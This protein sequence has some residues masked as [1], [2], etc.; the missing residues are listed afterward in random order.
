MELSLFLAKLFGIYF[1]IVGALWLFRKDMYTE[2]VYELFSSKA[3]LA[4]T[5]FISLVMGLAIAIGHPIFTFD[6]RGLITFFGY[7]G[8]LKGIIRIGFPDLS[9]RIVTKL[10][11]NYSGILL[12]LVFILGLFLTYKGFVR[13]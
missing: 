6:W 11:K 9:R 1:L 5:G 2:I 8:I 10:V 3:L 4:I 13:I 12:A 7:L